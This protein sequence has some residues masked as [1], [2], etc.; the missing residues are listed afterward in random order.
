M[1]NVGITEA[2]N[3]IND[4]ESF[5]NSSL[6]PGKIIGSHLCAHLVYFTRSTIVPIEKY[7]IMQYVG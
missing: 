4:N 5:R 3:D 7:L 1:E 2:N 6:K